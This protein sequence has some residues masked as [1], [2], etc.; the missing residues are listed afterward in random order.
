MKNVLYFVIIT[1]CTVACAPPK[2]IS[3]ADADIRQLGIC[4][5][6]DATVS[7]EM[8]VG[9]EKHVRSFINDYN[10]QSRGI[11]LYPCDDV[12]DQSLRIY[13]ANTKMI[14]GGQQVAG[15]LVSTVGLTTPFLMTAAGLPFF[16]GF[17]YFP[18][19]TTY[20]MLSLSNDIS[21]IANYRIDRNHA[22]WAFL[23]RPQKQVVKHTRKLELFLGR[24]LRELEVEQQRYRRRRVREAK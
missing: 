19:N 1:V 8:Q 22:S 21:E 17:Y 12:N 14:S 15:A 3:R 20:A 13:L 11:Y 9:F 7:E 5:D 16:V 4:V 18:H 10:A 2:L 24:V 6:Y 23:V